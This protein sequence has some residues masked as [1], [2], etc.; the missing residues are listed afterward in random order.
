MAYKFPYTSSFGTTHDEAYAR[1]AHITVGNIRGAE[2]PEASGQ[3]A[4]YS[5]QEAANQGLRMLGLYDFQHVPIDKAGGNYISQSYSSLRTVI[6]TDF[7]GSS[8]V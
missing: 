6:A 3:L 8:E 7:P 1:I 4:I 5:S 2:T